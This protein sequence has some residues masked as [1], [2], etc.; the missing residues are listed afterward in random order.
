MRNRKL[1]SLALTAA[2]AVGA[3]AALVAAPNGGAARR[4]DLSR[5]PRAPKL[6]TYTATIDVA[7]YIDVKS[8]RD[9]TNRCSPGQDVTI[10]FESAFELGRPRR[11]TIS[12]LNGI[13]AGGSVA[14]APGGVTHKGTVAAYRETNYCPPTKP[15]TLRAPRCTSGKGRLLVSFGTMASE[16]PGRDEELAPLARGVDIA[17][18]R[19]GGRVQDPSCLTYLTSGLRP[20]RPKDGAELSV[21]ETPASAVVL[22]LRAND[23]DFA[24]LASGATLRRVITLDGACDHVLIGRAPPA[25]ASDGGER[26]KCT[27]SGRVYISIRR[28]S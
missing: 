12:I 4:P 19:V 28:T 10:E 3:T 22:P 6:T 14:I 24:H 7:G 2:V 11:T 21:F 8:E 9:S 16:V 5:L 13:V 23:V 20:A 1:R 17:I 27:V 15:A 26:S 25:E 18:G